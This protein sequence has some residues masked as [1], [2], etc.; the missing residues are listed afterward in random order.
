MSMRPT[1]NKTVGYEP[2][3]KPA[4]EKPQSPS[5]MPTVTRDN[6]LTDKKPRQGFGAG[7]PEFDSHLEFPPPDTPAPTQD[8]WSKHRTGY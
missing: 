7:N 4:L 8:R 5:K 2:S 1:G 3:S 6:N